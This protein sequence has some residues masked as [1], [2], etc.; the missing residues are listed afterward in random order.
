MSIR[1]ELKMHVAARRA[2]RPADTLGAVQ[3]NVAAMSRDRRRGSLNMQSSR[4]PMDMTSL[5]LAM[6]FGTIGFGFL[7]YAK[8]AGQLIPGCAGLCLMVFPY[9]ISN[10]WV[11]VVVGVALTAA[12]FLL[13]DYS[14]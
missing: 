2:P 1:Y 14:G 12:P 4:Y 9:F 6:L 10:N 7:A 11:M 5:M 13:R 3:E 8:K